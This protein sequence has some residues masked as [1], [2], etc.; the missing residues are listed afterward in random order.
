M[1]RVHRTN[2]MITLLVTYLGLFTILLDG[3]IVNVALPSIHADLNA[4]LADLVDAYA[5]PLAPLC[6]QQEP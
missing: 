6:S 2:K 3:S 1:C 4:Q 5:L